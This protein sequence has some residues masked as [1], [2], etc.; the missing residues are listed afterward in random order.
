MKK[1]DELVLKNQTKH[2]IFLFQSKLLKTFTHFLQQIRRNALLNL[3]L[4][5]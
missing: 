4:M 3:I 2:F 5:L 1:E